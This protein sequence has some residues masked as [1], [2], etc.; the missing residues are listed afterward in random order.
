MQES[1]KIGIYRDKDI[2]ARILPKSRRLNF[3]ELCKTPK[4]LNF[5]NFFETHLTYWF[6]SIEMEGVD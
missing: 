1:C 3:H 2:Y 6:V 4:I 5:R